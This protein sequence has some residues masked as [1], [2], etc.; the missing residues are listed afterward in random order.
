MHATIQL[1]TTSPERLREAGQD[2][3][4]VP[5]PDLQRADGFVAF[6][7]VAQDNGVNAAI[8]LWQDRAQAEASRRADVGW[9]R[10]LARHGYRLA[11]E[12]GGEVVA[13]LRLRARPTA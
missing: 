5:F 9:S 3:A 1:R 13:Q 2:A 11:G 10:L 8:T 7:V 6:Y 4:D 12:H